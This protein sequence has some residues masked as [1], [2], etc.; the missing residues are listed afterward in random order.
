MASK[1]ALTFNEY[2]MKMKALASAG[3]KL[4]DEELVSYILTG[5][6]L[7]FNPLVFAVATQVEPISVRELYTQPISFEQRMEV[8]GG[9]SH[10]S[11]NMAAKGGR[12]GGGNNSNTG[13]C[14]GGHGGFGCGQKGG[15][16]GG[17]VQGGAPSDV[18][19]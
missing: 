1:G 11:A 10:S 17:R 3:K 8:H 6:D 13:G 18:V 7:D 15:H 14:G 5:L 19:C 4:E 16:G 12:A 2:F 9:G